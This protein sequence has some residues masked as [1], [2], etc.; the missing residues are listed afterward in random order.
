MKIAVEA[1]FDSY[2][3]EHAIM[4]FDKDDTLFVD[5]IDFMDNH[6]SEEYIS[7]GVDSGYV[8]I[9][10]GKYHTLRK[11][12]KFPDI[13]SKSYCTEL[14]LPKK[15]LPFLHNTKIYANRY[16]FYFYGECDGV[17]Y[18]SHD[19]TREMISEWCMEVAN[20]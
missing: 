14:N 3:I 16:H 4:V 11:I 8:G 20:V 12:V 10:T 17:I 15:P 1:L 2:D 6:K 18:Q 19:I 7:L 13:H 9:T 5:M